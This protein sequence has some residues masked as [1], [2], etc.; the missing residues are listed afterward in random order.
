M[1]CLKLGGQVEA[2]GA[3]LV[4]PP[5][6][7]WAVL[8]DRGMQ[9]VL[10]RAAHQRVIGRM[11]L[12]HVDAAALPVMRLQ[13]RGFEIGEAGQFLRLVRQ[14]EAAERIE[15]LAHGGRKILGDLDQQRVT[16]PGVASRQRRRLVR[17][18]VRHALSFFRFDP[19]RESGSPFRAL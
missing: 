11:E 12:D 10:H 4:P 16:T 9:P 6:F 18:L 1:A 3:D 7:V 17:Y 2:R 13:H 8:P 5:G 15:V 14:H 19:S